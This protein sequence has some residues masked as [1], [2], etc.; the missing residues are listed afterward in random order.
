MRQA[1]KTVPV[2]V[3]VD[4]DEGVA[5]LVRHLNT[6]SGVRTHAS[7]QGTSGEGGPAP[8]RAQ[9]MV[10][11]ADDAAFEALKRDFDLTVEGDHWGYLHPRS[12]RPFPCL[13]GVAQPC[14]FPDCTCGPTCPNCKGSGDV[15]GMT[16][17][18]GPDDYE[19]DVTCPKCKGTGS[20]A[21]SAT[22]M[23]SALQLCRQWI[24]EEEGR[25]LESIIE[26]NEQ[27]LLKFGK[28]AWNERFAAM[29]KAVAEATPSPMG[30]KDAAD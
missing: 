29:C 27:S 7:C 30:R 24:E 3:W 9:V 15:K 22:A 17:E 6:L 12:A 11:W 13:S 2:Q 19:F 28:T 21:P 18:H 5:D 10:T 8:Y 16:Y 26:L 20:L 4:V 25:S 23:P 1:H 14:R